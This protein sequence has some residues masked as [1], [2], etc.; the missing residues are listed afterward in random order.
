MVD[1]PCVASRNVPVVCMNHIMTCTEY[2]SSFYLLTVPRT[3]HRCSLSS[4]RNRT[5]RGRHGQGPCYE[6]WARLLPPSLFLHVAN[7]YLVQ[8]IEVHVGRASCM[9]GTYVPSRASKSN[10]CNKSG[11]SAGSSMVHRLLRL[12][13]PPMRIR[14]KRKRSGSRPSPAGGVPTTARPVHGDRPCLLLPGEEF[15]PPTRVEPPG[16]SH[17][18]VLLS[19]GGGGGGGG[20]LAAVASTI[21]VCCAVSA[22]GRRSEA[23]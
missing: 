13:P 20:N 3:T 12:P 6:R 11:R 15:H 8:Q 16:A 5:F 9:P 1:V 22:G 17:T 18:W 14:W 23:T 7:T 2:R 21:R 4:W 19:G 10:L